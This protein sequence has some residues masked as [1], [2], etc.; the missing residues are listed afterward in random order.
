[1]VLIKTNP[2]TMSDGTAITQYSNTVR[3]TETFSFK[4]EQEYL[5]IYNRGT[6]DIRYEASGQTGTLKKSERVK[7]TGL[8]SSFTLTAEQGSQ[9]FEIRADEAGTKGMSN[10]AV[11]TLD[12]KVTSL[13]SQMA[14]KVTEGESGAITWAMASQDFREQ[15][16]G[17]N[18][19]VVGVNAVL[20]ENI[21]NGAVTP[22]K[23]SFLVEDK[24]IT[25]L[26]NKETYVAGKRINTSGAYSD[27]SVY[28]ASDYIPITPETLYST[29]ES[30]TIF[31]YYDQNKTYIS[32]TTATEKKVTSPS[33]AYFAI[34][35]FPQA[36]LNSLMIVEWNKTP[37]EYLPHGVDNT[38]Y[39]LSDS[40]NIDI[41]FGKGY[42]KLK[43]RKNLF[44][45]QTTIQGYA[46][47]SST[48]ALSANASYYVSDYIEIKPNTNYITSVGSTCALYDKNKVFISSGAY[49]NGV[50][51]PSNAKFMRVSV[52]V[53]NI[54]KYQLE[55]GT[56]STAVVKYEKTIS[57]NELPSSLNSMWNGKLLSTVGD[58]LTNTQ[59]WQKTVLEMCGF[60]NYKV[61]GGNGLRVAKTSTDAEL[62]NIAICESVL[63]VDV[64]SHYV[65][66]FGGTNDFGANVPIGEF[67]AELAKETAD[68]Y[69]FYG[70]LRSIIE[71]LGTTLPS[72][73]V[74]FITPTPR[75]SRN[76]PNSLGLKLEDYANAVIKICNY[77]S[78]PVLDLYRTSGINDI[79]YS[80]YMEPTEGTN[81]LHYNSTGGTRIGERIA[82]FINKVG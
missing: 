81:Y 53:E 10:D 27:T 59:K 3:G 20:E 73:R 48:G 82:S 23:I 43:A 2:V 7:L 80:Y 54:D 12:S 77:Y 22:E 56:T 28:H 57:P 30:V 4:Q 70:A 68:K 51:T 74:V 39:L 37:V 19:A 79:T 33:N 25:N 6:Q 78:I 50:T 66:V 1:M 60:N 42:P 32:Q 44:N 35:V 72:A 17:G 9:H 71:F 14:Q 75:G 29:S 15:I 69:T 34:V 67:E 46:I 41:D 76:T 5:E 26:F 21:T 31:A 58:S 24:R 18:T 36:S 65:T 47:S 40:E 49:N 52:Q 62:G 11:A 45:R 16:T 13:T 64:N 38:R 55:E 63:S 8:F 61:Y